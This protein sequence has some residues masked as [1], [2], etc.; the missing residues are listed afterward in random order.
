MHCSIYLLHLL[1]M[2]LAVLTPNLLPEAEAQLLLLE[3]SFSL[4][5][6]TQQQLQHTH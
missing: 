3:G 5:G 2:L 1:H 4:D 6:K